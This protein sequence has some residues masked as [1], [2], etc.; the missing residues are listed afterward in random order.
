[1]VVHFIDINTPITENAL[2]LLGV[3]GENCKKEKQIKSR[4]VF[5]KERKLEIA[6]YT[7]FVSGCNYYLLHLLLFFTECN[8]RRNQI[9]CAHESK[10]SNKKQLFSLFMGA[11]DFVSVWFY[12]QPFTEAPGRFSK[13]LSTIIPVVHVGSTQ[14][15]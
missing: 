1:M 3:G 4:F 15:I 2:Q 10:K 9:L 7:H 11:P 6:H 13:Q 5:R 14:M 12:L 8:N